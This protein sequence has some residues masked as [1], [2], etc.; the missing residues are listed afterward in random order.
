MSWKQRYFAVFRILLIIVIIFISSDLQ[1]NPNVNK[2]FGIMLM[3]N[4]SDAVQQFKFLSSFFRNCFTNFAKHKR[5]VP[6]TMGNIE[7]NE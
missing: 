2:Y 7:R 6:A 5:P 1:T 3:N 4:V